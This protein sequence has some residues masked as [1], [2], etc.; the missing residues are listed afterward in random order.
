MSHC[1]SYGS[2]RRTAQAVVASVRW[3]ALLVE[4]NVAQN[5]TK[6]LS[7]LLRV[8][9]LLVSRVVQLWSGVLQDQVNRPMLSH[10]PGLL[11][12]SVV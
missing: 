3:A 4:K 9:V 5:L 11:L 12:L 7:Y 1:V 2:T 6:Q 8:S 10:A